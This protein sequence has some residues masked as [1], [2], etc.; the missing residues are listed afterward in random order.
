LGSRAKGVPGTF[1]AKISRALSSLVSLRHVK[2]SVLSTLT[3]VGPTLATACC[4][5]QFGTKLNIAAIGWALLT[6]ACWCLLLL[7]GQA[8]RAWCSLAVPSGESNRR[9]SAA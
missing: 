1:N 3:T 4:L 7:G 6:G 8:N 9:T 2:T 5:L